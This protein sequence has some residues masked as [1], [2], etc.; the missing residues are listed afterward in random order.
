MGP[1]LIATAIQC[2]KGVAKFYRLLHATMCTTQM[3]AYL[4]VCC[5]ELVFCHGASTH[6]IAPRKIKHE[7]ENQRNGDKHHRHNERRFSNFFA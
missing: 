4:E 7:Y 5:N 6:I 1:S 3:Y 2:L